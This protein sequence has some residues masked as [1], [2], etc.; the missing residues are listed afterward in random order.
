MN[1]SVHTTNTERFFKDSEIIVSKTDMQG[2]IVY[3]N[4][5][6]YDI[7][8]YTEAECTNKPHS[9]VRHPD[10]PRSVFQLLWDTIQNGQEIFA[11]VKNRAKN[12]DY[13]WVYAHVTP[14]YDDRGG[15]VGYHSNRRVPNRQILDGAIIPLYR[16]LTKEEQKHANRKDACRAGVDH[17]N[18]L[19]QSKGVSYD[20][21]IH[22]L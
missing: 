8:G 15:L 7:A 13:Y 19:L 1:E 12:G 10:M 11:Y 9:M 17:L 14:S 18:K 2:R 20:E 16:Q 21:F 4:K 6:F 22:T 5:L 3:G